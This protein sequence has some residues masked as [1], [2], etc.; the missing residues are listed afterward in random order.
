M[1]TCDNAFEVTSGNAVT[2]PSGK[3]LASNTRNSARNAPSVNA[4]SP[5]RDESNPPM[6][7]DSYAG[8]TAAN[9]EAKT[10]SGRR[11]LGDEKVTSTADLRQNTRNQ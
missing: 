10:T 9:N 3:L 8:A 6:T 5:D 2:D 1:S 4:A 7:N 11:I